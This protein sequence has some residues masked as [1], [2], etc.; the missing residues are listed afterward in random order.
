MNK[1]K[2]KIVRLVKRSMKMNFRSINSE[3]IYNKK[4]KNFNFQLSAL[5]ICLILC[6]EINYFKCIYKNV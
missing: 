1:N 3:Y 6:T 4:L 2:K 5:R